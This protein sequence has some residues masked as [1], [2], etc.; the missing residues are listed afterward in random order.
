M[1]PYEKL[2]KTT[3]IETLK[4]IEDAF[5]YGED[6]EKEMWVDAFTAMLEDMLESDAFGTEGQFD[7][8]GDHRD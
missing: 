2:T 4:R 6:V 7:P 8:R 1:P 3:F 5:Q